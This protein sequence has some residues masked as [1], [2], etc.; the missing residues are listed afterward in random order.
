VHKVEILTLFQ[1]EDWV[2]KCDVD[3]DGVLSYEE[4]K[5]ALAGNMMV[6]L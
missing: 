4:F 5:F 2:T 6:E 3:H 1:V